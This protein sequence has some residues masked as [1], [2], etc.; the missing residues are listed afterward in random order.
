MSETTTYRVVATRT[1]TATFEVDAEDEED[2]RFEVENAVQ[3]Y[4]LRCEDAL[5]LEQDD[6]DVSSVEAR[7]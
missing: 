6:W 4:E 1:V 3:S 2:A 5:T 7:P